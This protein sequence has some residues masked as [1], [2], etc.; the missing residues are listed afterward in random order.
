MGLFKR[1]PMK[2][3]KKD[4]AQE[5]KARY[6]GTSVQGIGQIPS[7]VQVSLSLDPDR[8]VL[9]ILYKHKEIT[10]PYDRIISFTVEYTSVDKTNKIVKGA[11]DF[12]ENADVRPSGFDPLGIKKLATGLAGNVASKLIPK[13]QMICAISVLSYLDKNGERQQLQFSN[14]METGYGINNDNSFVDA[15]AL[16][17]AKAVKTMKSRYEENITEL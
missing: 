15:Q 10:L 8:E 13:N 3:M 4:L 2:E 12:L 7:E 9:V 17:F 16:E 1:D 11:Q 14:S 6:T 5:R